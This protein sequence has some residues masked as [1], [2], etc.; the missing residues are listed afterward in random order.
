[1]KNRAE[2]LAWRGM[3]ERCGN[4]TNK[5]YADYGGRGITVCARWAGNFAAFL[6]DMGPR[7]SGHSLDRINND[8]N[9]E[10]SNCRWATRLQQMNNTRK[11]TY[12]EHDGKRMTMAE[13]SRHMGWPR[14]VIMSRLLLGWSAAEALTIP[15]ASDKRPRKALREMRRAS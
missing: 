4:P 2:R 7:P 5:Q 11:N 8:G 14:H 15:W 1:M 10:P 6:A 12:I 9:Y 13:W 3:Q